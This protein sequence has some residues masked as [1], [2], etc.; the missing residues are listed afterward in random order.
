VA[1]LGDTPPCDSRA[2][3]GHAGAAAPIGVQGV[4]L[5]WSVPMR[6]RRV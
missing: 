4:A 1:V 3:S 5:V 2:L 6:W